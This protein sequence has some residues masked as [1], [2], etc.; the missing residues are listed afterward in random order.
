MVSPRFKVSNETQR[1][2][3][4]R[5]QEAYGATASPST[6]VLTDLWLTEHLS[7]PAMQSEDMMEEEEATTEQSADDADSGSDS[8]KVRTAQEMLTEM[9]SILD[10]AIDLLRETS[11]AL[12]AMH[13]GWQRMLDSESAEEAQAGLQQ[14]KAADAQISEAAIFAYGNGGLDDRSFVVQQEYDYPR[15]RAL[16]AGEMTETEYND[17]DVD[18]R[19]RS[20][21]DIGNRIGIEIRAIRRIATAGRRFAFDGGDFESAV[22]GDAP[23]VDAFWSSLAESCAA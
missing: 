17:L 16:R 10:Q 8:T 7:S 6:E 1:I 3:V 13:E 15:R 4:A 14:Y 23:A 21:A 9:G 11:D 18:T 20:V 19:G 2:A 5:A 22:L 12:N